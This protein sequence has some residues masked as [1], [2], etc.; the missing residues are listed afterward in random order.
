M[1]PDSNWYPSVR[2][3]DA[4]AI[5]LRMGL[6]SMYIILQSQSQLIP[7]LVLLALP[8]PFT[9]HFCQNITHSTMPMPVDF[10]V[11]IHLRCVNHHIK[12]AALFCADTQSFFKM[13]NVM[14]NAL[15]LAGTLHLAHNAIGLGIIPY[16][17][18]R[19]SSLPYSDNTKCIISRLRT[20]DFIE[21]FHFLYN[22]RLDALIASIDDSRHMPHAVYTMHSLVGVPESLNSTACAHLLL[23]R[24]LRHYGWFKCWNFLCCF[25]GSTN[26]C[27][28]M[29]G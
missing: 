5:M 21:P 27:W 17:L 18:M 19:F 26:R 16:P 13:R 15:L 4:L 12:E 10:E 11:L 9:K 6:L 24:L 14:S 29:H 8:T 20:Q 7:L 3:T 2:Q 22:T 1:R 25:L 23:L 28:N